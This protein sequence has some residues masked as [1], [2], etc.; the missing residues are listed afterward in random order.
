MQELQSSFIWSTETLNFES[1]CH[2][3][4]VINSENGVDFLVFREIS[5]NC[6]ALD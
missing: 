1:V 2:I 5:K 4:Y 6:A 3:I